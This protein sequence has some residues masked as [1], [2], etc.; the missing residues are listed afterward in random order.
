[1]IYFETRVSVPEHIV[2]QIGY[3]IRHRFLDGLKQE[4]RI[5]PTIKFNI[6]EILLSAIREY[7][8]T[9]MKTCEG[10]SLTADQAKTI[11]SEMRANRKIMAIK[12]FRAATGASLRETKAFLENFGEDGVGEK[13]G[14]EFLDT[15]V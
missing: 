3:E 4:M 13:A 11:A 5:A 15:F 6:D 8:S 7:A 10:W 1:M 12:E 9:Q 14:L 2:A